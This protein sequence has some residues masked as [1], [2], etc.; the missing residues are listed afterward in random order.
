MAAPRSHLLRRRFFAISG[1]K[2]R[3]QAVSTSGGLCFNNG[4]LDAGWDEYLFTVMFHNLPGS[5]ATKI[6]QMHHEVTTLY[7]RLAT[8]MVRKP[9]LP[10]WAEYSPIGLFI[11]D[12]PVP[13]AKQGSKSTIADLSINDGLH[14]H[15]VV[16]GNRWGRVQV[17]L[18]EYFAENRE[19]YLTGKIRH[20]DVQR[21]THDQD[22][23]VEYALKGLVKHTVSEDDVLVLDWAQDICDP[24]AFPNGADGFPRRWGF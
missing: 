24:T 4:F 18:D 6:I 9:R 11:P 7:G 17:P 22:Y 13:K 12:L 3:E 10:S 8:R 2:S 5:K 1:S 23:V 20:V 21:I 14:L 16:L 19:K 15:G